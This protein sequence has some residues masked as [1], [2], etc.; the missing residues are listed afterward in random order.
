MTGRLRD[1]HLRRE[2][3][4]SRIGLIAGNTRRQKTRPRTGPRFSSPKIQKNSAKNQTTAR[5]RLIAVGRL[6]MMQRA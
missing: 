1:N 4:E 3:A 2:A 6:L 5:A